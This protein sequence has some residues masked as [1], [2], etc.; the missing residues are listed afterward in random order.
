VRSTIRCGT[1]NRVCFI[2]LDTRKV[3][4]EPEVQIGFQ[5][6]GRGLSFLSVIGLK[7]H[8]LS[9]G[10][11]PQ[12]DG[13]AQ[14]VRLSRPVSRLYRFESLTVIQKSRVGGL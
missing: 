5:Q 3:V 2:G 7:A 8:A 10:L 6:R 1:P 4:F 12:P 9:R 11:V 14:I 13:R